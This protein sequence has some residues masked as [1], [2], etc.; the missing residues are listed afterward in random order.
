MATFIAWVDA[1][2]H[3][4]HALAAF[5]LHRFRPEFRPAFD[6]WRATSPF[7]NPKAPST[8]FAMPEYTLAAR[9]QTQQLD[10]ASEASAA[11]VR[12]DIQRSSLY[13][14]TVVLYAIVLFFGGVSTRIDNHRLRWVV[15]IAG[16]LVLAAA[17][18]WIVTFP[19]SVQV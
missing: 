2:Q 12:Q 8:P 11:Q 18:G 1:A 6:A 4:D 5:Y 16:C 3:G 9:A 19:V 7:S 15:T 17:I 10:A 13:V 14:L